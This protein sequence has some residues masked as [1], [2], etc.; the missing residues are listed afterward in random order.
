MSSSM[1]KAVS[2]LLGLAALAIIGSEVKRIIAPHPV[3]PSSRQSAY[4]PE[5]RSM[6]SAA[7]MIGDADAPVVVTVF[8][9]FQC[10]FCRRFH[11]V[12]ATAA[13]EFPN[14]IS[15]AVIHLPLSGHEHAVAAARAAECA[16]TLELGGSFARAVDQLY[17]NQDSIGKWPWSRFALQAGVSDTVG[18]ARCMADPAAASRVQLGAALAAKEG[19]SATPIVILNGWRYGVP[20][21]DTELVRAVGDIVRGRQPYKGFPRSELASPQ[22]GD[23]Q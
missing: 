23:R 14:S 19:F 16:G 15:T 21:V 3:G 2:G 10:P 4:L 11:D 8:T 1:E 22:I 7:N 17:A 13:R 9:D 6:L 5:W 20:P 18:F 12:L